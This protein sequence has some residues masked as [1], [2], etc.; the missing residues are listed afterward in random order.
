M[1]FSAFC[2][3]FE[4]FRPPFHNRVVKNKERAEGEVESI[5][6]ATGAT[7]TLLPP[8]NATG[9]FTKVVQRVP[10]RIKLNH[11]TAEDIELLHAGLSAL[12]KVSIR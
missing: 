10:V 3:I 4:I 7:F 12:V 8:D 6:S 5:S 9:N 1:D 2:G 11:L